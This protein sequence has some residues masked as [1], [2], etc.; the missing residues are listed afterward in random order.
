MR[1]WIGSIVVATCLGSGC[2]STPGHA[3]DAVD[4]GI[5]IADAG[6][7]ARADAAMSRD[8]GADTAIDANTPDSGRADGGAPPRRIVLSDYL[9]FNLPLLSVIDTAPAVTLNAAHYVASINQ[10]RALRLRRVRVDMHWALFEPTQGQQS[11]VALAV[12]DDLIERLRG[13]GISVIVQFGGVP[14]HY[15]APGCDPSVLG[16]DTC[17]P[18]DA[19]IAAL[20]QAMLTYAQRWPSVEHWQIGNE[21]N[22]SRYALTQYDGLYARAA[23]AVVDAFVAAGLGDKLAL[24]GM[25][26]YGDYIPAP[27]PQ[28]TTKSGNM[29]RDV[30]DNHPGLIDSLAA[31]A[32]HPYTDTPEGEPGG[33]NPMTSGDFT[34]RAGDL[35]ASLRAGGHVKAIWATEF[36]WST[37]QAI[38]GVVVQT[39]ISPETQAGYLLRRLALTFALDFDRAYLFNLADMGPGPEGP[40]YVPVTGTARDDF[41]G[42]LTHNG[43]PKPAFDA[44]ACFLRLA[45]T[46]LTLTAAPGFTTLQGDDSN[47]LGSLWTRDDGLHLWM[48]RSP[49]PRVASIPGVIGASV[50]D[51]VNG[52]ATVADIVDSVSTVTANEQLVVVSY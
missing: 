43:A 32:Y 1:V 2:A 22:L 11:A 14:P 26:Y 10:L 5:T 15:A 37:Y 16:S 33:T 36:G 50:H 24:A 21:P 40:L 23:Q 46:S 44:L 49:S 9:G 6:P 41:Y 48:L 52:T 35:N 42:V 27:A 20:A 38:T 34:Q 51:C 29:L 17:P 39:P 4:T 13:D 47:S 7:D 8:A 25:G 18:S 30:V 28:Y 45:G 31:V 3:G 19:G 12:T